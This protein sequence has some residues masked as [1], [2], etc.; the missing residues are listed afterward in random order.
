LSG[1]FS[2]IATVESEKSMRPPDVNAAIPGTEAN[3][4][5]PSRW[6]QAGA[7][8]IGT[9]GGFMATSFL[10]IIAL[11]A[12]GAIYGRATLQHVATIL[13]NPFPGLSMGRD[14]LIVFSIVC[15]I[16]VAIGAFQYA[17]TSFTAKLVDGDTGR[18]SL[19]C[20]VAASEALIDGA[21]FSVAPDNLSSV[22]LELVLLMTGA[23]L[24]SRISPGKVPQG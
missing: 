13:T 3:Q 7:A 16:K 14:E 4:S 15:F 6:S 23:F 11:A 21:S 12:I 18:F 2:P 5:S 1:M 22:V 19:F 10:M 9:L 17:I 24:A 8:A 20:W